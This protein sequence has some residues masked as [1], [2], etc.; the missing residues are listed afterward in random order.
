MS[1]YIWVTFD[2]VH[3]CQ[4]QSNYVASDVI[5]GGKKRKTRNEEKGSINLRKCAA[6]VL[7]SLSLRTSPPGESYVLR[8]QS[9]LEARISL[10]DDFSF[11][12]AQSG[13]GL[14]S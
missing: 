6:P 9:H 8:D 3:S 4:S 13:G 14:L 7:S 11:S 10:Q 2:A 5:S 12:V 1:D